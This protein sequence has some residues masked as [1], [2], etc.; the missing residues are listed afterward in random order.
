M[1]SDVDEE[2]YSNSYTEIDANQD[3]DIEKSNQE[4]KENNDKESASNDLPILP[5]AAADPPSDNVELLGDET[6]PTPEV[7]DLEMFDR[8]MKNFILRR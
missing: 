5:D 8:W 7:E 2:V 6:F 1:E 3:S 4:E